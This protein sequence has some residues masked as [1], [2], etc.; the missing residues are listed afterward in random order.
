MKSIV[1]SVIQIIVASIS[2]IVGIGLNKG[3]RS[4]R[5]ELNLLGEEGFAPRYKTRQAV[6]LG[7]S[8][9][10]IMSALFLFYNDFSRL[11]LGER[12]IITARGGAGIILR[13]PDAK[14]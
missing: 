7:A 12:Y 9:I 4:S 13:F 14:A 3:Y 11:F 2:F 10:F 5:M 8:I 1:I 6:L